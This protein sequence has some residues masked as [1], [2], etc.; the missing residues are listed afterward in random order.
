M[1]SERHRQSRHPLSEVRCRA[2]SPAMS[3]HSQGGSQHCARGTG[4][5]KHFHPRRHRRESR[6]QS[7]KNV[8]K[9]L[10]G[11]IRLHNRSNQKLGAASHSPIGRGQGISDADPKPPSGIGRNV[12]KGYQGKRQSR[13]NQSIRLLIYH[14]RFGGFFFATQGPE[15]RC[16]TLS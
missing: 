12:V 1:G 6:S 13:L 7:N 11:I 5:F 9:R 10:C 15:N 4:T 3:R 8:P 16:L 2:Y 14:P